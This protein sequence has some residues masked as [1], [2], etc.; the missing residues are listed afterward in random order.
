MGKI[1]KYS[2]HLQ[3]VGINTYLYF[4]DEGMYMNTWDVF[5]V[6]LNIVNNLPEEKS[7]KYF[8]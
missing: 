4:E 3:K 8:N 5:T 7:K 1:Q 2:N 6:F